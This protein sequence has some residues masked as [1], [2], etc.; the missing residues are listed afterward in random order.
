MRK[1]IIVLMLCALFTLGCNT[2]STENVSYIGLGMESIE[3]GDYESAISNFDAA[4]AVKED[5]QYINRGRGIAYMAMEEYESAIECFKTVL[6]SAQG[7]V[8]NLEL[9]TTYYLASAQFKNG[10]IE[11]AIKTYTNIVSFDKKQVD[12]YYLRGCMY[13]ENDLPEKAEADFTSAIGLNASDFDMYISIFKSFNGKGYNEQAISFLNKALDSKACKSD[14]NKGIVYYYLNE[15][16]EALKSLTSAKG[17]G[18]NTASLY[19]GKVYEALEDVNSAVSMYQ[20]YLDSVEKPE[21]EA[22]IYNTMG[23]CKFNEGK[24]SEAL[25]YFETGIAANDEEHMRELLFN[26]ITTYEYL[27]DFDK[28]ASKMKNYVEKYPD[29]KVAQREYEFLSTR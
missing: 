3:N 8:S 6:S 15:T 25:S 11:E 1:K 17:A 12:A 5:S 4:E 10:N 23:M 7:S 9:D 22:A 21:D 18:N 20:E 27:S 28:A 14:L 2:K 24:Y 19:I 13:I 29:D 26:E 16:S